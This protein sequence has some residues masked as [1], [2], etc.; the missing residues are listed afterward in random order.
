MVRELW[1]AV[2]NHHF[3]EGGA[4]YDGPANA[5]HGMADLMQDQPLAVVEAYANVKAHPFD[6]TAID[7]EA[8]PLGLD[9]IE[10][11]AAWREAVPEPGVILVVGL[12]HRQ[13]IAPREVVINAQDGHGIDVNDRVED[14]DG[15][16]VVVAVLAR[17]QPC[18]RM[19]D[20]AAFLARHAIRPC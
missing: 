19:G 3:G 12:R 8:W 5:I 9:D 2:W 15:V 17:A 7:R 13:R 11:L 10:R 6:V 14:L 1:A 18:K 20:A 16:S 4:M